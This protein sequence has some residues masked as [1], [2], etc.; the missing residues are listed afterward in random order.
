MF[1][2]YAFQELKE[3]LGEIDE[4]RFIFTSP[5][6]ITEK[7]DK[8]CRESYIPRLNRERD[9]FGSEFEIKLRNELS[10]K[11]VAKEPLSRFDKMCNQWYEENKHIPF[12]ISV[13]YNSRFDSSAEFFLDRFNSEALLHKDST[14]KISDTLIQLQKEQKKCKEMIIPLLKNIRIWINYE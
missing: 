5:S 2:I 7:V 1:S 8:Q 13:R 12:R 4:L 10:L 3:Q 9:L 14:A 11:A 6:F